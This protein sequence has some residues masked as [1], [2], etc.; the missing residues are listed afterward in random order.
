[1]IALTILLFSNCKKDD[2][3]EPS[4]VGVWAVTEINAIGC[5]DPADDGRID[6]TEP[7][8][9]IFGIEFCLEVEIKFTDSQVT[10]SSVSSVKDPITGETQTETENDVNSYTLEGNEITTCELDGTGC[11]TSTYSISGNVLTVTFVSEEDGC[12]NTFTAERQ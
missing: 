8:Q 6:L 10:V 9:D 11:E 7:C 3:N 2:N 12:T 4:V 1:M 5:N